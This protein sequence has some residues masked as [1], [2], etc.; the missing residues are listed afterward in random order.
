MKKFLIAQKLHMSQI[1]SADGKVIPVTIL[2]AEPNK[3]T[4]VKTLEKDKYLGVQVGF[5]RK[6]KISKA[7]AG[8]I[9]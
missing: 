2:K 3:V 4:Q 9:R 6:K 5:G 7:Q 1:F 8:H